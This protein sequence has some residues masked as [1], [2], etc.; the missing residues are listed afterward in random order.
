[1]TNRAKSAMMKLALQ[2]F[3]D[4]VQFHMGRLEVEI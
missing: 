1:M 2:C 3:D 4:G